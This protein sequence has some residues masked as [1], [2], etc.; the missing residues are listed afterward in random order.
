V[1]SFVARPNWVVIWL[2]FY[3]L[4][5]AEL[6]ARR[7]LSQGTGNG[8]RIYL[9]ARTAAI[10]EL[11]TCAAATTDYL[12]TGRRWVSGRMTFGHSG[13]WE[14]ERTCPLLTPPGG[15]DKTRWLAAFLVPTHRR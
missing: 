2:A 7:I 12:K 1:E 6:P 14:M 8:Y 10:D 9:A 4:A 13:K 11:V 3:R 15:S 5:N